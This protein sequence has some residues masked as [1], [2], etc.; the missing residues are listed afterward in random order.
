MGILNIFKK[1]K[2]KTEYSVTEPPKA[3]EIS[4][5]LKGDLLKKLE[6]DVPKPDVKPEKSPSPMPKSDPANWEVF[7]T[8]D[9]RVTSYWRCNWCDVINSS[10]NNTC[11]V[12]GTNHNKGD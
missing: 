5:G 2:E 7:M 12:C 3:P 9:E 6:A 4:S 1:E 10:S 11:M 8:F